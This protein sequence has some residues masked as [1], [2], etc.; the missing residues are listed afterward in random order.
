MN[1]IFN[2][3][4]YEDKSVVRNKSTRKVETKTRELSLII[5]ETENLAPNVI[6]YKSNFTQEEGGRW[7]IIDKNYN[8]HKLVKEHLLSNVYKEVSVDNEK[9][10][11][12]KF[13]GTCK[14]NMNL[15]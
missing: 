2:D 5:N 11:I 6:S 15:Y 13:K 7:V 12:N 3:T 1:E 14:K 10:N 9:Q 8:R 4:K